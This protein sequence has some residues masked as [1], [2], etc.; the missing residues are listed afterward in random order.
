MCSLDGWVAG[1]PVS[2]FLTLFAGHFGPRVG[3]PTHHLPV[4]FSG[5]P[6]RQRRQYAHIWGAAA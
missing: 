5:E 3:L 4:F 6:P 2:L 1:T